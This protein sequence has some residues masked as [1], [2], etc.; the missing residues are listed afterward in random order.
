MFDKA[1]EK[2]EGLDTVT[3]AYRLVHRGEC[4]AFSIDR[5][6]DWLLVTGYDETLPSKALLKRLQPGLREIPRKG[7]IVR[8]NLRDPH[9]RKLFSDLEVFGEP[10]PDN[11]FVTEHGLK[12][13]ISLNESQHP[14]LFLDQRESR[15]RVM[16][17][18]EGKRV[19]NLFSFT[20]SFSVAAVAGGAEVAFSVDLAAGCL[21][22][23]KRNFGANGLS[24][25]GRGK[26]IKEDARKWLARQV[27]RKETDP[28]HFPAWDLIVC[29]PPVFAA[30]PKKGTA[31]SVEKE[32]PFLAESIREIL[33]PDGAALFANNHR[34]G[35]DRFY[36]ST[37]QQHFKT[38]EPLP[39]PV[40]FPLRQISG[41]AIGNPHVR[42]YRCR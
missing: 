24:E 25:G 29:D 20:C 36:F 12:Y 19:A 13:E 5:Y 8:T 11:F 42:T 4:G 16:R 34:G 41:Q 30:T 3:D 17:A 33:A 15:L 10:A 40:D 18:A 37:L 28:A 2:R 22:R 32:W 27:R 26:F 14:G 9:N 21:K 6:G 39:P 23:G 35:D 31:F 7:G 38:V 1:I